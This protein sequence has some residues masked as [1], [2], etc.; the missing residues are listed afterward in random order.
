ME[1]PH[2]HREYRQSRNLQQITAGVHEGI[3][4]APTKAP[5]T[6]RYPEKFENATLCLRLGQPSTLSRHE[7]EAYQKRSSDRRNF[8][9]RA[10]RF[11]VDRKHLENGDYR[12]R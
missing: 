9:T 4:E 10:L 5:L 1:S 2:K 8:K 7:N 11:S 12:K 6:I 3:T